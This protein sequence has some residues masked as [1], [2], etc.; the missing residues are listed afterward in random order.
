MEATLRRRLGLPDDVPLPDLPGGPEAAL[1]ALGA[2]YDDVDGETAQGETASRAAKRAL[3]L[4]R[5]ARGG[6][7]AA[8]RVRERIAAGRSEAASE[9]LDKE[10]RSIGLPFAPENE[11]GRVTP[12]MLADQL[13]RSA[14]SGAGSA[15]AATEAAPGRGRGSA[16][17]A[18][19]AKSRA[20]MASANA[21][22]LSAGM[23]AET[24]ANANLAASGAG[25]DGA[26]M[27][28]Q[29][30]EAEAKIMEALRSAGVDET[31]LTS[32]DSEALRTALQK[33]NAA[34]AAGSAAGTSPSGEAESLAALL[35]SA[36][37]DRP[38]GSAASKRESAEAMARAIDQGLASAGFAE[39]E[40]S[41][42]VSSLLQDPDALSQ[43]ISEARGAGSGSAFGKASADDGFGD[44]S[45]LLDELLARSREAGAGSGFAGTAEERMAELELRRRLADIDQGK[46]EWGAPGGASGGD[47]LEELQAAM[48]EAGV[49]MEDLSSMLGG[50]GGS[51]KGL[52]DVAQARRALAGLTDEE[53]TRLF[54]SVEAAK[55]RLAE[56]EK[57]GS[58]PLSGHVQDTMQH[59]QSLSGIFGGGMAG[60]GGMGGQ[61]GGGGKG[62]DDRA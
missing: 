17:E 10:A 28:W 22:I 55:Q 37:P 7:E 16:A 18:A 34:A 36:L 30:P 38:N 41:G 19:I 51:S 14:G 24:A 25:A 26:E 61:G 58:R 43:A 8:R 2:E 40:G 60:G 53:A 54:G 33:V 13:A 59:L 3:G 62:G 48:A 42:A 4:G 6:A 57:A 29:S 15:A 50:A 44:V 39:G 5:A 9:A 49:G 23:E 47:P 21:A 56:M 12:Q 45:S 52:G 31:A 35:E 46:G 27:D 20:T 1:Q 11:G 32:G